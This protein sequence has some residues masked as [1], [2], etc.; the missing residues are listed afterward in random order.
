L[1][2]D[3][4]A[5]SLTV[6]MAVLA[7]AAMHAGWN[8]MLKFELDRL[9]S[10]LM[11]TLAMG[12]FGL[13]MLMIFPRPA[14]ASLPFVVASGII[15]CGYKLFLIRAYTAGD[16]SQVYPLARGTAPLLITAAAF[17]FAGEILSPFMALGI[18]L[19]LAG[20]YVLGLHGGAHAAGVNRPAILFALATSVFIAAYSIVDGLGVRQSGTASGYTAA[21]F[22]VDCM[23]FSTVLFLWHGPAV[24]AGMGR[25]WHKGAAAGALS[26]GSYWVVLWAMTQAPI[27]VVAA[28]R[29]TSILFAM[30]LGV[31]W[32]REPVTAWRV[33]AAALI[34]TGAAALRFG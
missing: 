19:V 2:D 34:V 10:M 23:I 9:R 3:C 8:A 20:I 30:V 17:V 32:L 5:L 33:A 1:H 24:L 11:L 22:V 15:H 16:L 6:F 31:A 28:L 7:A 4:T 29:E 14:W 25:Q 26:L 12:L 21:V 27:G 18:G 13:M